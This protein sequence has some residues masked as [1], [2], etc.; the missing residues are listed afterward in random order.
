MKRENT[1]WRWEKLY[2]QDDYH[3]GDEEAKLRI[4]QM[5]N[6][7]YRNPRVLEE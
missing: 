5:I 7:I 2:L 1:S 4:E 6:F 3:S